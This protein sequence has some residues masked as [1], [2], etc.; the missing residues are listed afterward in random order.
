[1]TSQ[2]YGKAVDSGCHNAAVDHDT[3]PSNNVG[4]TNTFSILIR[5]FRGIAGRT[6]G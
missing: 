5:E 3:D 2:T 6:C 1:V 4:Y